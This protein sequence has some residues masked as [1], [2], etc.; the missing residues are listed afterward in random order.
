MSEAPDLEVLLTEAEIAARVAALA[1]ALAPRVADDAVAV[2]L[3]QGGLWFAAD[4][5]RALAR[6][7]RIVSGQKP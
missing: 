3:L 2:C 5:T 4:L 6:L 1:E 7:G